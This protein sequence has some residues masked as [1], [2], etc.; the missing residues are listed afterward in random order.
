MS[1]EQLWE[2]SVEY[3]RLALLSIS[4]QLHHAFSSSRLQLMMSG[5]KV[6]HLN[7]YCIS[8]V[9]ICTGRVT[10]LSPEKFWMNFSPLAHLKA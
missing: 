7:V 9:H 5:E 1:R 2:V 6:E 4:P 8:E 3:R 10:C